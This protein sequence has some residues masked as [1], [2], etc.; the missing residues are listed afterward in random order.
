MS[1]IV[2]RLRR[3]T[4]R[5]PNG[6]AMLLAAICMLAVMIGAAAAIEAPTTGPIRAQQPITVDQTAPATPR[7][8]QAGEAARP[9]I[10]RRVDLTNCEP[11]EPAANVPMPVVYGPMQGPR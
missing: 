2:K 1:R 3:A 10:I 9:P 5:L 7:A 4:A 8:A 11:V 6:S